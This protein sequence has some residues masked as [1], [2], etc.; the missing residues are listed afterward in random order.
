M[1]ELQEV[2]KIFHQGHPNQ[3][4]ALYALNLTLAAGGITMFQGP[5]GCG[6]TT[7]LSLIGAMA[8]PSSGRITLHGRLLSNL[9]E[10]FLTAVRRNTFGFVFQQFHLLRGL[11]VLENV[12]LPAYPLG[13]PYRE[14]LRDAQALLAQFAIGDKAHSKVEWLS[15]GEAQRTALARALIN[16]PPVIIA[17]EPTAHLDS[18][19]AREILALFGDLAAQGRTILISSHDPLVL[20]TLPIKRRITLQDGRIIADESC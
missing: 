6:K 14:L 17:D 13:R 4:Q 11:S 9:P 7:L 1:I 3:F 20:E 5:S 10:R 18:A 16:Q 19:R 8:R 15:G 2:N 12:M